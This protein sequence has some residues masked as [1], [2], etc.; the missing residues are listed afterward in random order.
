MWRNTRI[1]LIKLVPENTY[2]ASPLL[3]QRRAPHFCSPSWAP[4]KGYWKSATVAARDLI[5]VEAEREPVPT[6]SASGLCPWSRWEAAAQRVTC[7]RTHNCCRWGQDGTPGSCKV[8]PVLFPLAR[9]QPPWEAGSTLGFHCWDSSKASCRPQ[10]APT[11]SGISLVNRLET[12]AWGAPRSPNWSISVIKSLFCPLRMWCW[13]EVSLW[14]Q[15]PPKVSSPAELMS[16]LSV[17][18]LSRPFCPQSCAHW[19]LINQSQLMSV[20]V[21]RSVVT[22]VVN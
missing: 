22:N 18:N 7:P 1:E 16:N 15:V 12:V 13:P 19:T 4:F 14:D 8:R 10:G 20:A 21:V 6:T 17:Q 3:P 11:T 9:L 2:F 5:L